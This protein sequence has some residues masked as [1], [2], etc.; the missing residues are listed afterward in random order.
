[1]T[2]ERVEG[3]ICQR[4]IKDC[5]CVEQPRQMKIVIGTDITAAKYGEN[6]DKKRKTKSKDPRYPLVR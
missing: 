6:R 1:M 3:G 2:Q 4:E 5:S